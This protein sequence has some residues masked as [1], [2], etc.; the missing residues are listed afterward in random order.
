MCDINEV[1][2]KA[3]SLKRATPL[4]LTKSIERYFHPGFRVDRFSGGFMILTKF[5]AA[6]LP[7]LTSPLD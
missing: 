4:Y 6:A 1:V 7:H 3:T 2:I 5:H